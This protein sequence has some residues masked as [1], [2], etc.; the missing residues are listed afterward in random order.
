[1]MKDKR[2]AIFPGSFDPF[3]KGHDYVVRMALRVFDEVVICVAVN[4]SKQGYFDV[5]ARKRIIEAIYNDNDRVKVTSTEG[6]IVD[7]AYEVNADMIIKG[8]RSGTDFDYEVAQADANWE[9]TQI[10]TMV[11][12]THHSLSY[13]SSTLI[14]S[15]LKSR[16]NPDAVKKLMC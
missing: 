13:I 1:M 3:H 12:P 14:R 2:I 5:E 9:M 8:A 7:K 10:G 4:P 11:I 16:Q 6:L 15:I